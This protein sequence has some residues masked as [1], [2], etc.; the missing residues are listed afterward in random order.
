M[1]NSQAR[2]G[3]SARMFPHLELMPLVNVM[4]D[5]PI[6]GLPHTAL[7][8]RQLNGEFKLYTKRRHL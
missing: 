3:N 4:T 2:Y 6:P 8:V 1:R 7:G 5:E